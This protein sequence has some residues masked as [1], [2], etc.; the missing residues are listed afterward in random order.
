MPLHEFK[1]DDYEITSPSLGIIL[2]ENIE[3]ANQKM[4]RV[5]S[6][7]ID[8]VKKDTDELSVALTGGFAGYQGA[9]VSLKL[10]LYPDMDETYVRGM[11]R[12]EAEMLF[13]A[14]ISRD[15]FN[16][17]VT[18]GNQW[19]T[20][21]EESSDLYAVYSQLIRKYKMDLVRF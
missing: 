7:L 18:L 16:K 3:G 21:A 17:L 9:H 5:M 4:N 11:N 13:K 8:T 15:D 19:L 6:S 2:D 1:Y 12:R 14:P 10:I 20:M